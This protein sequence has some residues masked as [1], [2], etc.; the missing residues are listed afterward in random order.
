MWGKTHVE[1]NERERLW[2]WKWGASEWVCVG[3]IFW[4]MCETWVDGRGSERHWKQEKQ[5]ARKHYTNPG[6]NGWKRQTYNTIRE[7]HEDDATRNQNTEEN[8]QKNQERLYKEK[9]NHTREVGR[10]RQNVRQT[11]STRYATPSRRERF[12]GRKKANEEKKEFPCNKYRLCI[13]TKLNKDVNNIKCVEEKT[14]ED[15]TLF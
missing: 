7:V 14:S 5:L 10:S 2:T 13:W 15:S 1:V 4:T 12:R 9:E 8:Y 11:R 3:G 6:P